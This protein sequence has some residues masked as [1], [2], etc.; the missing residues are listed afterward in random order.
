M[1]KYLKFKSIQEVVTVAKM[2]M[3]GGMQNLVRQAQSMQ[4]KIAKMQE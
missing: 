1:I 2:P 4:N 3:M